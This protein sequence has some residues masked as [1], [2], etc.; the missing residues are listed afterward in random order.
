MI[1]RIETRHGAIYIPDTDSGQYWWLKNIGASPEDEYIEEVCELLKERPRGTIIDAGA[2]FGCWTLALAEHA[3]A[4]FAIEPQ[5]AIIALLRRTKEANRLT[6]V[7]LVRAAL[8]AADGKAS[9]P[10][11]SLEGTTNFGGISIN[12]PHPEHP[13]A[14]MVDVP[15]MTIDRLA[16]E[17][18]VTFIKADV[19]G[20]E[21]AALTGAKQT[22]ARCRPI[23]FVESDHP[24][25]DT[26]ELAWF[27]ESMGYALEQRGNNWLGMPT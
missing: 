27:I 19:E 18:D 4:M 17:H 13:K 22:I 23:L 5:A 15:M 20:S 14:K 24:H 9:I 25:T 26:A 1:E 12:I 2:N 21:K 10:D 8:G 3:N 11:V 16:R 7:R 6:K